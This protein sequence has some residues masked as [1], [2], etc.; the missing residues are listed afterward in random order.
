VPLH[1]AQHS[2]TPKAGRLSAA[3]PAPSMA[4]PA[5]LGTPSPP[6]VF[7]DCCLQKPLTFQ[8]RVLQPGFQVDIIKMNEV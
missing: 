3:T 6:R 7:Q 4:I 8:S 2:P 1:A 5:V